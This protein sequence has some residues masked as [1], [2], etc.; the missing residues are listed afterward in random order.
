MMVPV[1]KK[2]FLQF[3]NQS[4]WRKK[5]SDLR[6]GLFL[7]LSLGLSHFLERFL[8]QRE[9]VTETTNGKFPWDLP[10]RSA[11]VAAGPHLYT[12]YGLHFIES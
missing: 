11:P 1:R 12:P 9:D 4:A 2:P 8:G 7:Q 5:K 3:S 6:L 10:T